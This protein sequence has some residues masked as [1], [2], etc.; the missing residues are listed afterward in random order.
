MLKGSLEGNEA[1]ISGATN[2]L[3]LDQAVS[4]RRHHL[5]LIALIIPG[6]RICL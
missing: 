3:S 5:Q 6:Q 4:Q 2:I 1:C